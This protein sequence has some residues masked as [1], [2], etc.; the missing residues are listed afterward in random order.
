MLV[1]SIMSTKFD[2][3]QFKLSHFNVLMNMLIKKK[4]K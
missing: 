3:E 4:E 1:L 2:S